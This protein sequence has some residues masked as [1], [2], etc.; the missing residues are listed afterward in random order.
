[1]MRIL[2]IAVEMSVICRQD[3]GDIW[4]D[5]RDLHITLE[6]TGFHMYLQCRRLI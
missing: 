1:M 4:S 3:S 5:Q 2:M 6:T